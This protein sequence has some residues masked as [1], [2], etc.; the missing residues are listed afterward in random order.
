MRNAV[1]RRTH[2]ERAQP[3][4]RAKFG[5]LE[6][7]SDYKQRANNHAAKQTRFPL[8]SDGVCKSSLDRGAS[9]VRRTLERERERDE[10]FRTFFGPNQRLPNPSLRRACAALRPS[11]N[12]CRGRFFGVSIHSPWR[13]PARESWC[14]L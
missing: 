2:K 11:L 12:L 3:A 8:K 1:A 13:K 7:H 6:K 9:V 10:F 4:A 14:V 5:L